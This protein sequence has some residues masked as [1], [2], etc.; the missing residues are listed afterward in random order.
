[1]SDMLGHIA[2]FVARIWE[3][4]TRIRD[5]SSLGESELERNGRRTVAWIFGS[6]I[7]ILVVGMLFFAWR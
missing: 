3:A 1:M 5:G 6:T 2:E 4:D 7:F